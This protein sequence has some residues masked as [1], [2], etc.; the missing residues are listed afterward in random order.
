MGKFFQLSKLFLNRNAPT[1]LTVIGA[2]GVIATSVMAVK[3][4]PKA[5]KLLENAREEKG[6][7]L[8]T[9]ETVKTAAPLYI[10]AAITGASTIACIFGANVLNKRNQASLVSAYALLDST[11]KKYRAKATELYGEEGDK[12]IIEEIA[13]D[14]LVEEDIH[15]SSQLQLFYDTTSM[16]YFESTIEDVQKAEFDLNARLLATGYASLNHLYSLL[17]IPR[18][19]YGDRVGW[20]TYTRGWQDGCYQII[21]EHRKILLDD[22]LECFLVELITEPSM[23]YLDY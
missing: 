4:T 5:L 6:E 12:K 18:V 21:F 17:D 19:D 16:R 13:K 23:E 15:P 9:W 20:T 2:G 1:I 11:Y 8:T 22:G 7:E 3:A 10:P 14:D